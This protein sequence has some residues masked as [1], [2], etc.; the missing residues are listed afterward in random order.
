MS[1]E[2]K[3]NTEKTKKH[4]NKSGLMVLFV[5]LAAAVLA[6]SFA[7]VQLI[8]G[9]KSSSELERPGITPNS[10][11]S[12]VAKLT[13]GRLPVKNGFSRGLKEYIAV[14]HIEGVIEDENKT[15]NQGWLLSTISD[16]K[17]D[18]KNRGIML[19]INS[20][21]GGVYQADEVYLE[22]QKYRTS[23][24]PVY[25][26]MG[27]LAASGGYYIACAAENISANRNTLTGSIGVIAGQSLDLTGLM[28]KMGIKSE[29]ITAGKNKNM[30]NFNAPFTPEQ[31]A[32]MQSVADEA[33]DQ[34]TNIVAT[35]R[36]LPIEKVKEL[37]D[38]RIYTAYQA[39]NN[40]LI[41]TVCSWEDAVKRL[42]SD[43][44]NSKDMNIED[45]EVEAKTTF[46]D[47]LT[48]A[49]SS[50][51]SITSSKTDMLTQ[52]VTEAIRPRI[53]Y[54]AYFYER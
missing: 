7:L 18:S 22:L 38:G 40:G 29:T 21:G 12:T 30:M 50:I 31:K 15:Y 17:D 48:G 44:F 51:R 34:F 9:S 19:Y 49:V 37:A 33:Y 27:P 3:D 10:S 4:V 46:M 25:A 26:Y 39:L 8:S 45:Y 24:K 14:I 43:K 5:I 41:D 11:N 54:P 13:S 20:P 32:I 36:K 23:G 2:F 52:T 35:N 16:L 42:E 47:Y 28:D 53:P 6:G 1:D